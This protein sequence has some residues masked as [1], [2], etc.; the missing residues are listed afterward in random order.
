MYVFIFIYLFI[1]LFT[2]VDYKV[3]QRADHSTHGGRYI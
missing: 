2:D 3:R 1:Y